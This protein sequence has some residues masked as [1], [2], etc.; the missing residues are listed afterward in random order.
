MQ[1][2]KG[3]LFSAP[4]G[5]IL[6][7]SCN[8]Q[9]VWGGGIAATFKEKFPEAYREYKDYCDGM[10][11]PRGDHLL[12]EENG[13]QDLSIITS[14]FYGNWKDPAPVILSN[15]RKA[16]TNFLEVNPLVEIHLPRINAGLFEVPWEETEKI[17][18]DLETQYSVNFIIYSL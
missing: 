14:K 3:D 18:K 15:T 2:I 1:Y 6:C 9:G 16:L 11:D 4:K 7:H 8:A 12:T 13:F 10:Q 17:L 5:S